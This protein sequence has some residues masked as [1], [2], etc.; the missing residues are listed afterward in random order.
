MKNMSKQA[1]Q[2]VSASQGGHYKTEKH[3][4]ER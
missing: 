4:L 2:G 3:L 1:Q